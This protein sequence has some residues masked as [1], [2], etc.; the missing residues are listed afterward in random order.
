MAEEPRAA[1]EAVELSRSFAARPVLDRLSFTLARGGRLAVLGANGTGK[2]TLL[3]CLAGSLAPTS[4]RVEIAGAPAG[5]RPAA[6]ALGAALGD[7][8]SFYA[9]LSVR[10]N[11]VLF[12]RLRSARW[13]VAEPVSA[14]VREL[15]LGSFAERPAGRCSAG[16]I[17]RVALAR[18]LLGAPRVLVL[19]EPT[20]SMDPEARAL[21]W[22]ALDRRSELALVLATHDE[23][24]AGRCGE[25]LELGLGERVS[26]G[27]AGG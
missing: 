8:R 3:R 2:T 9:R 21:A 7:Q 20:R 17:Q 16:Q 26:G 19:D 18:A 5:T 10:D 14:L 13:R 12:A 1:V 15:E 22:A 25:R 6:L 24:E 23:G 11:L 27:P 4:G